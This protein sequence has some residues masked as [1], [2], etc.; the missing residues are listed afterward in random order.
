MK[1]SERKLLI[2]LI[3]L[4]LVQEVTA[5]NK[6]CSV[7]CTNQQCTNT[8]YGACTQCT[9]P[10]SWNATINACEILPSTGWA[11]VDVSSDAGGSIS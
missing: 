11:L 9:A 1:L 5:W 6:F 3:F 2:P 7:Q 4:Y 10:W 8:S